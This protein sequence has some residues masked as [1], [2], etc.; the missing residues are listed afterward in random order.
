[1]VLIIAAARDSD[2]IDA[3]PAWT[4]QILHAVGIADEFP[5]AAYWS[6][7]AIEIARTS[8]KGV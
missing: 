8:A 4:F 7:R 2:A 3:L 5:G 1:M 6:G